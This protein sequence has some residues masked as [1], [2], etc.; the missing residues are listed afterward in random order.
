M[1][2]RVKRI[3]KN[4]VK[5]ALDECLEI[6]EEYKQVESCAILTNKMTNYLSSATWYLGILTNSELFDYPQL[7]KQVINLPKTPHFI[8]YLGKEE[9]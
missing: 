6:C 9:K 4:E 5:F 8:P 2:D 1:L 3:K 7:I